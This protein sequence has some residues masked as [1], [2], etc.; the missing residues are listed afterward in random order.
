VVNSRWLKELEAVNSV[1][2]CYRPE[3]RRDRTHSIFW[4]HDSTSECVAQPCRV[5]MHRTSTGAL[6]GLMVERLEEPT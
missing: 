2:C 5:E 3:S 1:H 4:F 6:L